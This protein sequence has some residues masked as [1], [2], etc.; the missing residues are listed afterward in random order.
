MSAGG[1]GMDRL[2]DLLKGELDQYGAPFVQFFKTE[3]LENK[4]LERNE[5]LEILQRTLIF[6]SVVE[7]LEERF[8]K[9]KTLSSI[10][11]YEVLRA[12]IS[13]DAFPDK[14]RVKDATCL[15]ITENELVGFLYV[16]HLLQF[17]G[18]QFSCKLQQTGL[19]PEGS[20]RTFSN[21]FQIMKSWDAFLS[22]CQNH[23]SSLPDK[24]LKN[25]VEIAM[26]LL[27]EPHGTEQVKA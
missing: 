11:V 16:A 18:H 17:N 26:K 20:V 25:G 15:K 2:L 13:L 14:K 5:I 21:P 23:D 8:Q 24:D 27:M 6:F 3:K 9:W 12:I 22:I 19:F 1:V 10:Q 4:E 7:E